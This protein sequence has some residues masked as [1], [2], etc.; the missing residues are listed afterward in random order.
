MA[1]DQSIWD[2]DNTFI[3]ADVPVTVTFDAVNYTGTKGTLDRHKQPEPEG[4]SS[5]YRFSVYLKAS[6]LAT[7]PQIWDV[8]TIGGTVY[9]ILD[10]SL[11]G[12]DQLIRFDMGEEFADV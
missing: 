1:L 10:K 2:T 7:V 9:R 12:V 11:D 3:L 8:F 5:Q 6:D 4:E